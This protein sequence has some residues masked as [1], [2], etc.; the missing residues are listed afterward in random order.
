MKMQR[1]TRSDKH[2]VGKWDCN[3]CTVRS[4][5]VDVIDKCDH[6]EEMM[7][8]DRWTERVENEH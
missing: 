2:N 3:V 1:R 4:S 5:A 7:H 8:R 6:V